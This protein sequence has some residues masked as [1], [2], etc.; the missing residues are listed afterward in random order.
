MNFEDNTLTDVWKRLGPAK[1]F[2]GRSRVDSLVESCVKSWPH[3]RFQMAVTNEYRKTI[4]DEFASQI[5]DQQ[6]GSILS[7]L[8]VGLVSAVVQVLLEWWLN[9]Q[10]RVPFAAWTLRLKEVQG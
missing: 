6:Y 9:K 10:Y 2:I 1:Y 7:M 4:S 5:A 3:D 8:L